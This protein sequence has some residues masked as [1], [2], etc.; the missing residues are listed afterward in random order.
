MTVVSRAM[1]RYLSLGPALPTAL[2]LIAG[3]I[4]PAQEVGPTN[5]QAFPSDSQSPRLAGGVELLRAV[6]RGDIVTG[7][8]LGCAHCPPDSGFPTM[9]MTWSLESVTF[10]H[11]LSPASDDAVLWMTGCEPHS[12]NFGGAVLLTTNS[13]TWSMLWYRPGVQV[14]RCHK[15]PLSNG[16]EILVCIGTF[17]GQGN[18]FTNIYVEDLLNPKPVL[19]AENGDGENTVFSALD[20]TWTCGWDDHGRVTIT[21]IDRV[22]FLTGKSGVPLLSITASSG[23]GRA[24]PEGQ[25]PCV[26][27]QDPARPAT[28]TFRIDFE[29][30]GKAYNELPQASVH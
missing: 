11:F 19:M 28:K 27:G 4:V 18:N 14:K 16:R 8:E 10:G 22:E 30:D 13:G 23:E 5:E 1:A 15:L 7:K 9:S 26:P 3:A 12:E 20:N 6:C 25:L 2:V 24:K 17:G 21:T 29:F